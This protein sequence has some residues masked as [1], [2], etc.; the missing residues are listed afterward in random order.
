MLDY[1]PLGVDANV[2]FPRTGEAAEEERSKRVSIG[3]EPDELLCVYT[4]RFTAEKNPLVLARAVRELRCKSLRFRDLFVGSGVQDN[5]LRACEGSIVHPMVPFEKLPD[6]F[7]AADIGAWPTQES[8]M[9]DAAACGI[10]IVVNDTLVAR[11]RIDG[12]GLRYRLNDSDDL[13]RVLR[14]LVLDEERHRFGCIGARRMREL[15]SWDAIA[16]RRLDDYEAAV[17]G[18]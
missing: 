10:P 1:C 16:R 5:D 14:T 4:G 3:V 17:K 15:L 9:L 2:F 6:W 12:N 18:S 7:Q 8:S 13:A 11:E